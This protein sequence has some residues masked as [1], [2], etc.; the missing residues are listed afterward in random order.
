LE[1]EITN[2][3]K[4]TAH[5]VC[6]CK[7]LVV[8]SVITLSMSWNLNYEGCYIARLDPFLQDISI[9][10]Y[11]PCFT[12]VVGTVVNVYVFVLISKLTCCVYV[13][14]QWPTN[15]SRFTA[16]AAAADITAIRTCTDWDS[17]IS[18]CHPSDSTYL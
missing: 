8:V 17:P 13:L 4:H 5:F 1:I 12:V 15:N 6:K 10:K 11:T 7:A 18:S 14:F 2:V 3:L 9:W 16:E